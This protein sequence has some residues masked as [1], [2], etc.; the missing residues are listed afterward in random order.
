[1]VGDRTAPGG[2]VPEAG[3]AVRL[4]RADE[5]G[6]LG[7]LCEDLRALGGVLSVPLVLHPGLRA[8]Q[9][10]TAGR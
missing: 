8:T 9:V 4:D 6:R 1:M 7:R 3:V 10:A 5:V 2:S